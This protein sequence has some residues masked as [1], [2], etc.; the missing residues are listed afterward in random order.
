MDNLKDN[1]ADLSDFDTSIYLDGINNL[2]KYITWAKYTI[3]LNC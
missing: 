1:F 3:G 2:D